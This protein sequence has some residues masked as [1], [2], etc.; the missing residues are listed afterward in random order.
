[1]DGTKWAMT[2]LAVA[3]LTACAANGDG[4]HAGH[5]NAGAGTAPA[6]ARVAVR[7]PAQ[8]RAHTLANMRD[9]LAALAEI[10]AA[11][12]GE[13]FDEAA[14]VAES[15]LGMSSLE[16]HDARH[17]AGYMPEGMQ[18]AGTRM[19]RVASRFAVKVQ[20]ASV[21]RDLRA[22]LSLLHE[23]TQTCVACHAAYRLE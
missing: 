7:F 22:P 18:A 23:L 10:Q 14:R 13:R 12:A 4:G 1:M 6:D 2:G 17:V 16:R 21:T 9:H 20:E 11:L 3:M 15:R 19:H 5:G 8:M